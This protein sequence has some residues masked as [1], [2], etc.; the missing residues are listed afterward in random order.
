[1][2]MAWNRIFIRQQKKINPFSKALV[3]Q[4]GIKLAECGITDKVKQA[5]IIHNLTQETAAH[6]RRIQKGSGEE[7]LDVQFQKF[8]D[9]MKLHLKNGGIEQEDTQDELIL[10]FSNEVIQFGIKNAGL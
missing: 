4:T 8:I 7:Y 6:L 1:M 10:W 2:A 9:N 3:E 5:K